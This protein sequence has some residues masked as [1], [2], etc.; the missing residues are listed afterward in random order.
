LWDAEKR[1][2]QGTGI[3]LAINK[4]GINNFTFEIIEQCNPE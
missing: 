2:E 1:P 3:D 4:Y